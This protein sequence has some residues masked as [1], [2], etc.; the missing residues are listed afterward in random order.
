MVRQQNV[1]GIARIHHPLC[2]VD[3][4][5]DDIDRLFDVLVTAYRSGVDTHAQ[6][7]F[8]MS[9]QRAGDLQRASH[10]HHRTA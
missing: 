7:H 10:R 1:A 2:G 8:R 3:A 9:A 4:A 6:V 5:A